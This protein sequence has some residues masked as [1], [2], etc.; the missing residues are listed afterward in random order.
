M[1]T[2][3]PRAIRHIWKV[4]L[5]WGA[6]TLAVGV[7]MLAKPAT[8]IMVAGALLAAYL[9]ISG[10]AQLVTGVVLDTSAMSRVPL[11]VT[12]ALSLGLGGL[13]FRHF[14]YAYAVLLLAVSIGVVLTFEGVSGIAVGS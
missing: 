11:F 4:E 7:L 5:A 6:L 2:R 14:G 8:S 9:V 1:T 13:A 12:G 3:A 10:I